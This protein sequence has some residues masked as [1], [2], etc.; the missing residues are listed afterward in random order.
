MGPCH[1]LYGRCQ[2]YKPDGYDFSKTCHE[3]VVTNQKWI[4]LYDMMST[5]FKGK[6]Y[7]VTCDSAYMGDIIAHVSDKEW[8]INMAGTIQL[9][10]VG[11]C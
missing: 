1:K 6:G 7:C 9:H 5:P 3:N 8:K 2:G 10:W 11:G 4:N